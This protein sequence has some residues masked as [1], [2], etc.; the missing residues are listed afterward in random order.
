MRHG[1]TI[2]LQRALIR[3]NFIG[4]RTATVDI[5][6]SDFTTMIDNR[7]VVQIRCESDP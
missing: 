2:T 6:G 1:T 4:N 5:E 3:K 7:F